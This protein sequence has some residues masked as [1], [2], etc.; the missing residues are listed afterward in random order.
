MFEVVADPPIAELVLAVGL[1]EL[2]VS[3]V[4]IPCLNFCLFGVEFFDG[5]VEE[6]MVF[7]EVVEELGG[8]LLPAFLLCFLDMV[9]G[10]NGFLS[11]F[12]AG[13]QPLEC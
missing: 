3:L 6:M 13:F 11:C 8:I 1:G 2:L 5:L 12:G 4:D 10:D 7:C 9:F